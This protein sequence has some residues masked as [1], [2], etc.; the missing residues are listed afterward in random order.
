[1]EFK[2]RC[3]NCLSTHVCINTGL[4]SVGMPLNRC[5]LLNKDKGNVVAYQLV[6]GWKNLLAGIADVCKGVEIFRDSKL[7]TLRQVLT[8]CHYT[9]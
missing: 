8:P 2:H 7:Q 4:F 6:I 5:E 9:F 1:M 3:F